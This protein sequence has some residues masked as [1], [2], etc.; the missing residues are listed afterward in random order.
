MRLGFGLELRQ[1]SKHNKI[2]R[3]LKRRENAKNFELKSLYIKYMQ[4]EGEKDI[5][6]NSDKCAKNSYVKIRNRCVYTGKARGVYRKYKMSRVSFR[7][8][9]LNGDMPGFRKAS[10]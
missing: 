10:W 5:E 3:D 2:K 6:Y 1:G 8:L 9:C 7:E 4:K